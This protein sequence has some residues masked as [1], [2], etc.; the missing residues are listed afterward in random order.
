M[1]ERNVGNPCFTVVKLFI[2]PSFPPK[3]NSAV[4]SPCLALNA[5]VLPSIIPVEF[6]VASTGRNVSVSPQQQWRNQRLDS[7]RKNVVEGGTSQH[8]NPGVVHAEITKT[9]KKQQPKT[10]EIS[11]EEGPLFTLGLPRGRPA[12]CQL[13]H[14]TSGYLYRQGVWYVIILETIYTPLLK[15]AHRH[16]TFL[17]AR[18]SYLMLFTWLHFNPTMQRFCMTDD[19][20]Q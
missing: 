10:T 17:S 14:C 16:P 19:H 9:P 13:R 20:M 4:C 5:S 7:R 8:S 11:A 12:P 2:S 15:D 18:S 6:C 1:V 3:K